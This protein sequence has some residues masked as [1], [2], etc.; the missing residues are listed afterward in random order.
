MSKKINLDV[1]RF[2]VSFL[3]IAI[4]ISPFEKISM[5]FDF[6]F[7]RILGRIAVPLYLMITGYYILDKSLKDQNVLKKYTKK[8]LK[9]YIFCIILYLPINIYTGK[10]AFFDFWGIIKD[11]LI[12]GTL[13]HLWYFPALIL[14]LW[15]IYYLIKKVGED[16]TFLITIVLYSIGLLG[17]S[18]YGITLSSSILKHIFDIIFYICDYTRN[19]LFFVPI[20][21]YMGYKI[22]H[23]ESKNNYDLFLFLTYFLFMTLEGM[24]LHWLKYQRH[25]SMYIFL[26]PV[27]FYLFSFLMNKSVDSNKY[28]R[29]LATGIYIFHPFVIVLIRFIFGF[30]GTEKIFIQS[31][32]IF[33]II[34]SLAT[35]CLVVVIEKVKEF[36]YERC[37]F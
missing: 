25:D 22:K 34:V 17:D 10:F 14:G 19:G 26:M 7:T 13:Y 2:I 23:Y 20:F 12:N 36:F 18:Y 28:L 31:N 32:F 5:T 11:L 9:V 24:L 8:I 21:I 15:I 33:Y 6:F 1:C 37:K 16:K 30:F 35:L 29:N 3:I 27:M 4:H